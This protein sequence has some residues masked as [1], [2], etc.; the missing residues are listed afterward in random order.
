MP[1]IKFFGKMVREFDLF[2]NPQL[3]RYN[4]DP[5]YKTTMGGLISISVIAILVVLFF[6]MAIKTATKQIITSKVAYGN[7]GDPSETKLKMGPSGDMMF[8]VS[9][10]GQTYADMSKAFMVDI[11]E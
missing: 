5:D 9:F 2:P 4:G 11:Y 10:F 1:I 3:L 7:E 8:A 6:N